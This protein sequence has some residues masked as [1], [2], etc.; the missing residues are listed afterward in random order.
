[1]PPPSSSSSSSSFSLSPSQF[2]SSGQNLLRQFQLR[3]GR[4]LLNQLARLG[5]DTSM[6]D[7]CDT[8]LSL[9]VC[10]LRHN[11]I[12]LFVLRFVLYYIF[13]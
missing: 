10:N 8:L 11:C 13:R 9:I 7:W 2:L 4:R 12:L 1:P 6:S 5:T 3:C